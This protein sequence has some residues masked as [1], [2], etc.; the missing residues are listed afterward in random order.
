MW[1]CNYRYAEEEAAAEEAAAEEETPE[2][3]TAEVT[4]ATIDMVEGVALDIQLTT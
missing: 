4:I 3:E 2:E 1:H